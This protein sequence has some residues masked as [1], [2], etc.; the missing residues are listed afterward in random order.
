MESIDKELLERYRYTV[1]QLC[2]WLAQI[3][4]MSD[5]LSKGMPVDKRKYVYA[6]SMLADYKKY[7]LDDKQA[8]G[9]DDGFSFL[10]D[11]KFIG[12]YIK[13]GKL[14]K[15]VDNEEIYKIVDKWFYGF[16][17]SANHYQFEVSVYVVALSEENTRAGLYPEDM[18]KEEIAAFG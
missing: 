7:F 8:L 10:E 14:Y 12:F 18:F 1:L 16:P 9:F 4:K 5:A 11:N 2:L 15:E 3:Q 6:C 17:I 13:D